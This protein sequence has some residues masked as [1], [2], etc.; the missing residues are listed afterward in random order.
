MTEGNS[1]LSGGGETCLARPYV[2]LG[3]GIGGEG[4]EERVGTSDVGGKVVREE[5]HMAA[6]ST[7]T[8]VS[9]SYREY[10]LWDI[11]VQGFQEVVWRKEK[12]CEFN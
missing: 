9:G 10:T 7:K 2:R 8:P 12:R 6:A 1:T 4:S 3:A 5:D 11:S